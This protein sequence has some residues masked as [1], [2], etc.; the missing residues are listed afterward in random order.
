M[1]SRKKIYK[2]YDEVIGSMMFLYL[3]IYSIRRERTK[4][5][6]KPDSDLYQRSSSNS[7]MHTTNDSNTA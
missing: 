1:K 4:K 6:E 5:R 7:S 2:W 3:F